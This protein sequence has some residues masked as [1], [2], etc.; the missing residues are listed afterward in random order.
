MIRT[1]QT[2]APR[3]LALALLVLPLGLSA[4]Y[5]NVRTSASINSPY[6]GSI[7]A[8]QA[9]FQRARQRW[10][11]LGMKSYTFRLELT[12][13]DGT[14][15]GANIEVKGGK[16]SRQFEVQ[17]NAA[18]L[19]AGTSYQTIERIFD[20]IEYD[21]HFWADY[22]PEDGHPTWFLLGNPDDGTGIQHRIVR[23]NFHAN[24]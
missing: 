18:L 4:C 10:T 19:G 6:A 22:S 8:R 9:E 14:Q 15:C 20:R 2:I 17:G 12:G 24:Q 23:L 1:V 7:P 11:Q 5:T 13:P 3:L 16:F 21:A